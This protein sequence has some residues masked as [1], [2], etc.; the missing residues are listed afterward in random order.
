MK[1]IRLFARIIYIFIRN[2]SGESLRISYKARINRK[3]RFEGFNTIHN[4][5]VV[6]GSRI[7]YGSYIGNSSILPD[8]YIGRFCSISSDVEILPYAHPSSTFVSTHPAFYS[9]LNQAG[10]RFTEKQLFDEERY[11]CKSDRI[12]ISIG[13]DVW[14]GSRVLIMGGV[15]IG[16]GAIV[17]AGAVV[18]KDVPPH[19]IVAGVPAR[20]LR[21][22][23]SAVQIE[24][25][26]RVRWWNRSPA[27]IGES[28]SLF[29]DV[30][31]FLAAN[32][33]D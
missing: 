16:D 28:A 22:R 24:E 17:A 29:P 32:S 18:T 9:L 12:S 5:V 33:G 13:N 20:I 1:L 26:L 21:Y 2:A 14:I 19:A 4:G 23:F 7:G 3:T 25:L 11:Y 6:S 27:Q 15:S 8:A 30:S 10:F 31:E